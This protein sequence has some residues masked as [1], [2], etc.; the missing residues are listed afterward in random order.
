MKIKNYYVTDMYEAMVKI[1][2]ELGNDAVIISKRKVSRKGIFGVLKPKMLE[3]TAAVIK[4]ELD[5]EKLISKQEIEHDDSLRNEIR[6]IRETVKS[7]VKTEKLSTNKINEQ[8]DDI[9]EVFSKMDLNKKIVEDFKSYCKQNNMIKKDINKIVLYEFLINRFN[10]KLNVK[11][12]N[13]RIIVLIG[14]TGVGKTTTIAKIASRES[15][16]N[17]RNVGIITIDT[18]R[19]G[20]VEQLKIYANILDIPVEVVADKNNIEIALNN[21]KD[22]DLILVDTTGSSYKN[23]EQMNEL[24]LYLDE[25]KEKEISLVISMTSKNTDFTQILKN[26]QYVNFDNLILTKF[27]ETTSYGNILNAFYL[28]D[29]PISYISVGQVVPDDLENATRDILFKYI[30][31][32]IRE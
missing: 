31:G 22:C 13:F 17:H 29:K 7:L 15:L 14:P 32:E 25:I 5:G 1:K 11:I 8:N 27:D 10:N 6:E 16:V 30:L 18:Y 19:I 24:K 21:L 20:A 3:V 26:Y 4:Q 28:V 2:E 12:S 23:L 9:Y